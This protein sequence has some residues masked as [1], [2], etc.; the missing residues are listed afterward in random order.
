MRKEWKILTDKIGNKKMVKCWVCIDNRALPHMEGFTLICDDLGYKRMEIASLM[1][2]NGEKRKHCHIFPYPSI[3][4]AAENPLIRRNQAENSWRMELLVS[5][6]ASSRSHQVIEV[7]GLCTMFYA[8]D[9]ILMLQK[10]ITLWWTQFYLSVVL[11]CLRFHNFFRLWT[12]HGSIPQ[13]KEFMSNQ[14]NWKIYSLAMALNYWLRW[15]ISMRLLILCF[16]LSAI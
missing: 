5:F 8:L 16:L 11:L 15:T 10:A 4:L 6:Y 9:Q 7:T 1:A 14:P 3:S 2:E 13:K 12:W